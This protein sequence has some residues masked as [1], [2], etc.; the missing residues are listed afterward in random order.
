METWSS[1]YA[2]EF[3]VFKFLWTNIFA[4]D[5]REIDTKEI[6]LSKV[7]M[8]WV[9]GKFAGTDKNARL[10]RDIETSEFETTRFHSTIKLTFQQ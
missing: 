1:T 7:K 5:I 2:C 9:N 10:I 6:D 3:T 4:R 8:H